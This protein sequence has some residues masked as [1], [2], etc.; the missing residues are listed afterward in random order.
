[1]EY[2]V[3]YEVCH[4]LHRHHDRAFWRT[5]GSVMPDWRERKQLLETSGTRRLPW[6]DEGGLT[7]LSILL[8]TSHSP[9][10]IGSLKRLAA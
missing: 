6:A 4:L 5:L 2:V 9:E 3:A 7:D 1:M 8:A 10:K